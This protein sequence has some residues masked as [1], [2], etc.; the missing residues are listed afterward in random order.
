M[1][2]IANAC[3]FAIL[4]LF[5]AV[6]S[7]AA[8]PSI[9]R[10]EQKLPIPYQECMNRA[11]A[12]FQGNG[13]VNLGQGGAFVQGF[14]GSEAAYITC[15]EV[16][17]I[18]VIN[19]FVASDN[20]DPNVPGAARVQLQQGMT[21]AVTPPPSP[22]SQ[23]SNAWTFSCCAGRWNGPIWINYTQQ[24]GNVVYFTGMFALQELNGGT[25]A[26]SIDR[27]AGTIVF[28]R[29]VGGGNSQHYQGTVTS[30]G[31]KLRASGTWTGY[32]S[33]GASVEWSAQ[34]Q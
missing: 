22:P 29:D 34:Q 10:G 31:S 23:Q 6:G 24:Q 5:T 4:A 13:W 27:S 16:G 17:S 25:I 20:Q 26:G 19:V 2:R 14:R 18:T 1:H 12:S 7:A 32:G 33:D 8:T 3:V 9:S 30:E 28:D 21:G 11:I 15:N